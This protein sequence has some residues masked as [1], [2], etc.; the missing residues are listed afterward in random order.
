MAQVIALESRNDIYLENN[1]IIK[2]F[3]DSDK[4]EKELNMY[5]KLQHLDFIPN[6]LGFCTDSLT[7]KIEYIV[8]NSPEAYDLDTDF[9]YSLA[10]KIVTIADMGLVVSDLHLNNIIINSKGIYLIDFEDYYALENMKLELP[11]FLM[12]LENYFDEQDILC[13]TEEFEYIFGNR[14]Y[15]AF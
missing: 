3:N 4:F 6:L 5:N 11:R 10:S 2:E 9:I 13:M 1:I 15:E 12:D 14:G 7:L 8:G